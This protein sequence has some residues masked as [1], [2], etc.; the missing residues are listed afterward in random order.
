[1]AQ[2][3]DRVQLVIKGVKGTGE[4]TDIT[5]GT[6]GTMTIDP[7]K[8][9][10]LAGDKLTNEC[11][12]T[13]NYK[14][15]NPEGQK[16]LSTV[17]GTDKTGTLKFRF[18]LNDIRTAKSMYHPNE[19]EAE[20]Q[21]DPDTSNVGNQGEGGWIEAAI[22]KNSLKEALANRQVRLLCD[23]KVY[24][25]DFYIHDLVPCYK[26]GTTFVTLRM[27]SPD[28][29][30]T[31]AAYS[32]TWVSK[33][34]SSEL[35][36]GEAAHY[37]LPWDSTK[38]LDYATDSMKFVR[39]TEQ[40]GE[41]E[42]K[43]TVVREHIFPYLVQYNETFYDFL[44]RTA[45]RWGE[46]LFWEDGRLNVG[47]VKQAQPT[48][49]TPYTSHKAHPDS[50]HMYFSVTC[51]DIT[52]SQPKQEKAGSYT[53]QAGYDTNML[54]APLKKDGYDSLFG[55]LGNSISEGGDAYWLAKFGQLLCNGKNLVDFVV[56]VLVDDGVA[57]GK[58]KKLVNANNKT[59]NKHYFGSP[60]DNKIGDKTGAQTV[61]YHEDQKVSDSE[62]REFTEKNPVLTNELYAKILEAELKAE[63]NVVTLDFDTNYP[64][65]KLG[66]QVSVMGGSYIVVKIEACH[67]K[68]IVR[69]GVAN[70]EIKP[71]TSKMSYKVVA[72]KMVAK[73]ERG[74]G[75]DV[76][77][78]PM[79]PTGHIRLSGPQ[80]A[81]VKDAED[82]LCRNRV[83]IM[84]NWQAQDEIASPWL[85]YAQPAA[86]GGAGVHGRHYEE[87]H[88]LVNFLY[89][90][91]E[92]PYVVGAVET[93]LPGF[94]A[95]DSSRANSIVLA[96]PGG[97]SINISDG[98]PTGM[99][100]MLSKI[101]PFTNFINGFFPYWNWFGSSMDKT[102]VAGKY[103]Q[104]SIELK[105]RYGIWKIKGCTE[106]RNISIMSPWGDIK[107]GAFTGVTISAPN[108]DITIK[109]KNITMEAG[110]NITMTSGNNITDKFYPI[111]NGEGNTAAKIALAI[112]AV[113]TKKMA[114]MVGD[115]IDITV[116]RHAW[117]MVAKPVEGKLQLTSKRYLMLEAGGASAAYPISAYK[118][119]K[120]YQKNPM[121]K[122]IHEEFD[123]VST[124]VDR[125]FGDFLDRYR[126][127]YQTAGS[128]R[129]LCNDVQ[130]LRAGGQAPIPPFDLTDAIDK[131]WQGREHIAV[132]DVTWS[133][134]LV[135]VNANEAEYVVQAHKFAPEVEAEHI[136]DQQ[137]VDK[138]KDSVDG[139][140]NAFVSMLEALNGSVKNLKATLDIATLNALKDS[141]G[142]EMN[143]V[144][145][146][147][148]N[149]FDKAVI[150]RLLDVDGVKH[151]TNTPDA[152][153]LALNNA[154]RKK[155]V[156]RALYLKAVSHF[157]LQQATT[158]N[159]IT[160]LKETPPAA[161]DPF[162]DN[163][164]EAW[165]KYVNS[166]QYVEVPKPDISYGKLFWEKGGKDPLKQA[167]KS[168]TTLGKDT[169]DL[170]AFNTAEKGQIL[171]TGGPAGTM[172][173]S[174]DIYRANTDHTENFTYDVNENPQH[175][176]GLLAYVRE[177]MTN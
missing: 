65:L 147:K 20:V 111:L 80:L 158:L 89:G 107:M 142:M 5:I 13:V 47:Y 61:P 106:D 88:V 108:G 95:R 48:P 84:Y 25:D 54:D 149:I 155:K 79:L 85:M 9:K 19:I 150:K 105:D 23:N 56:D 60:S 113:V 28:K 55:M 29:T 1:M 81:T 169:A 110:N 38:T 44:A 15:F 133:G 164:E 139:F 115:I 22:D 130:K 70:Y 91:V 43:T 3:I 172:V 37:K 114:A 161:P 168:W 125:L 17:K 14:V 127:A 92:R 154:V 58:A 173:L 26:A 12:F 27:F 174:Q 71:N 176:Q 135:D 98:L 45:N 7:V 104:G 21:I 86:T 11:S 73:D 99:T 156:R 64:D 4:A 90:N 159:K 165:L 126:A 132:N 141:I 76:Y 101:F 124:F 16:D 67:P 41:G 144:D 177:K 138:V 66:E 112:P 100:P 117:E 46:F 97:H 153:S 171:F 121:F 143:F 109:G 146:D 129:T 134:L 31:L 140:R 128:I 120:D 34:M 49:L 75:R 18:S 119:P 42:E 78:P 136:Q 57:V 175:N 96:S 122:R 116:L 83:R 82:P 166:L 39:I 10:V 24:G 151:L 123:H 30:M 167:V 72:V 35:L 63:K 163:I 6:G 36:K 53:P 32:R 93:A 103:F 62:Y 2:T 74:I 118:K 102:T 87:E 162:G 50:P 33:K 131:M 152:I 137:T 148:Q 59:F 68:E 157:H 94:I 145:A 160:G 77:L 170:F 52:D 8:A 40:Q 69:K 51:G